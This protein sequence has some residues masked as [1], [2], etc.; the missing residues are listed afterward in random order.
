MGTLMLKCPTTGQEFSSGIHI[1]E[2]SFKELPDTMAEVLCPHCGASHR[3]RLRE[4]R[5]SERIAPSGAA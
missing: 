3:W 1:E 2:D 4:A 5:F